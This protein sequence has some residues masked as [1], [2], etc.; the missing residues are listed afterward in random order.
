M[1]VGAVQGR[2]SS[3]R[4]SIVVRR[5][6]IPEPVVAIPFVLHTLRIALIR[7]FLGQFRT[8]DVVN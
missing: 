7:G 5:H 1:E 3:N 8:K 2:V 6:V 4:A